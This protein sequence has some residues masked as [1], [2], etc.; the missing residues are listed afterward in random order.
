MTFNAARA[1]F[2]PRSEAPPGKYS[3]IDVRVLADFPEAEKEIGQEYKLII[4]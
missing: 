4:K 1:I 3:M 2:G